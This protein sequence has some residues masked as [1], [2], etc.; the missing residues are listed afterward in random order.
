MRVLHS[1]WPDLTWP[2]TPLFNYEMGG[3]RTD[4]PEQLRLTFL[5]DVSLP[6]GRR[7]ALP[8]CRPLF[9]KWPGPDP[10]FSFGNKKFLEHEG[11]PVFAE[12][13]ILRLLE[14]A[15]WE[16]RWVSSFGGRKFLRDMPTDAKLGPS[17]SLPPEQQ[18]LINRISEKLRSKGGCFDVFAW[19]EDQVLFCDPKWLNRDKLRATQFR[20]MDAALTI[21]L[22][23]DDLLVVEWDFAN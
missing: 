6:S 4:L 3:V 7:L 15:G 17:I 16:G 20:W 10:A 2:F 12:I 1:P 14:S 5:R 13:K 18:N 21:G 9:P 23:E 19:K 11:T 8:H 22:R